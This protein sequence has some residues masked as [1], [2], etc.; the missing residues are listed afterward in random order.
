[1]NRGLGIPSRALGLVSHKSWFVNVAMIAIHP[2]PPLSPP[3]H[4]SAIAIAS[5]HHR[6]YRSP[7][8]P[9]HESLGRGSG[10]GGPDSAGKNV[11]PGVE[12][13]SLKK[14]IIKINGL[15]AMKEDF[16]RFITFDPHATPT[17]S[18]G[19]GVGGR[20]CIRHATRENVTRENTHVSSSLLSWRIRV[21]RGR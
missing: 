13:E 6:K 17:I 5:H 9:S 11:T 15:P 16:E 21:D 7:T 19:R 12:P 18:L 3:F 14:A 1:M 4:T 8:F 2:L 20:T 10:V